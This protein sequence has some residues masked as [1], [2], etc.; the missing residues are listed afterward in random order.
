MRVSLRPSALAI[1]VALLLAFSS[2]AV[3]STPKAQADHLG[4]SSGEALG[5][6]LGDQSGLFG[7][8]ATET[9]RIPYASSFSPAHIEL[10]DPVD[11]SFVTSE[12]KIQ[13]YAN[14]AGC[15]YSPC[16]TSCLPYSGFH[17]SHLTTRLPEAM[18]TPWCP[19]RSG[20]IL[21]SRTPASLRVV[22]NTP[23]SRADQPEVRP[24]WESSGWCRARFLPACQTVTLPVLVRLVSSRAPC[25]VR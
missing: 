5:E 16:V 19:V 4:S 22:P 11:F 13:D 25:L 12:I 21:A 3:I 20:G 17:T 7:A 2:L 1:I 24:P 6:F 9:W 10:G 8:D 23:A 14:W 15:S 18:P